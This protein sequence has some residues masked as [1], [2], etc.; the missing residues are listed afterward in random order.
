MNNSNIMIKMSRGRAAANTTKDLIKQLATHGLSGLGQAAFWD[1]ALY[2]PDN[3]GLKD[4]LKN[5]FDAATFQS[6]DKTRNLMFYFNALGGG[7]GTKLLSSKGAGNKAIGTGFL[8]GIP[9]KDTMII[10]GRMQ[11]TADKSIPKFLELL[12]NP[13]STP[14]DSGLSKKD[15][16]VA[17]AL[18][19]GALGLGAYGI[20]SIAKGLSDKAD[21]ARSGR[22]TLTLPTK[23]PRD[24]ETQVSIPLSDTGVSAKTYSQLGRDVRRRL[25][26]ESKERQ[27]K[28]MEAI[29][30]GQDPLEAGMFKESAD[31]KPASFLAGSHIKNIAEAHAPKEENAAP[32]EDQENK[33]DLKPVNN[34]I[35]EQNKKLSEQDKRIKQLEKYLGQANGNKLSKVRDNLRGL[36]KKAYTPSIGQ[37]NRSPEKFD[38]EGGIVGLDI[39]K[40]SLFGKEGDKIFNKFVRPIA[41]QSGNPLIQKIF[42]YARPN[43]NAIVRIGPV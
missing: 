42:G 4:S 8:F 1:Q 37:L 36:S 21:A 16:I 25:R 19:L 29:E 14:S 15:K 12:A 23:D 9:A 5:T 20:R 26:G 6:G 2:A 40:P 17:A 43:P 35:I 11:H 28:Y 13:K 10:S 31:N 3:L 22:V 39:Y 30:A 41:Q 18:G 38:V 32:A 34:K 24:V 27:Q 33:T 7:T